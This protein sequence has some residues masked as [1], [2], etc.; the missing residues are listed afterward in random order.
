MSFATRNPGDTIKSIDVDQYLQALTGL[1]P[2]QPITIGQL[3]S[4]V[5]WNLNVSPLTSPPLTGFTPHGS[6]DSSHQYTYWV[7]ASQAVG[8]GPGNNTSDAIPGTP[9]NLTAGPATYG[10]TNYV[11]VSWTITPPGAGTGAAAFKIL[12]APNAGALLTSAQYVGEQVA[13]QGQTQYHWDD[14]TASPSAYTPAVRN[15]GGQL[16]GA[17]GWNFRAYL[18]NTAATFGQTSGSALVPLDTDT[19]NAYCYDPF[20]SFDTTNHIYTIPAGADGIWQFNGQMRWK[21]GT[22]SIAGEGIVA[23]RK[24]GNDF[25]FG[26]AHGLSVPTSGSVIYPAATVSAAFRVA[27]TDTIG[28]GFLHDYT[29]NGAAATVATML[30]DQ[31]GLAGQIC[32]LEGRWVAP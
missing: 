22:G 28:L 23:L 4:L 9:R 20:N 32:Y 1:M 2:D 16:I 18:A 11:T 7:V 10:S 26:S 14:H 30:A 27:A 8:S 17:A 29:V 3:L 13:V 25:A 31:S 15:P 6:F 12:R 19:G 21:L 24:N 5:G